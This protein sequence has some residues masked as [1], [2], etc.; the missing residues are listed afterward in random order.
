MNRLNLSLRPFPSAA[1]LPDIKITC[2][3]FRHAGT[4]TVH[5]ELLGD[6]DCLMIPGPAGRPDRKRN[7]W[8]ETCLELFL[9]VPG[10]PGYWEFN[11]SPA[12]HWNV[13]R[14]DA[15]RQGMREETAITSLPFSVQ[16]HRDSLLIDLELDLD[17]IIQPGQPLEAAISAVIKNRDGEATY[18]ALAHQAQ[19]ADFH[20][21]D[22]FIELTEG[23]TVRLKEL[24]S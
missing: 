7:L 20:R 2:G 8:E 15:Y 18:W 13:F 10:S 11:L 19:H 9:G 17:G 6:M 12:G 16:R 23:L 3:I 14:F 22:S 1:P 24:M 4:I 5:Y 21:R